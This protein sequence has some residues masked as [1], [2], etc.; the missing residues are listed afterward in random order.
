VKPRKP[1]PRSRKR[2]A[3][4]TRPR[5]K[6]GRRFTHATRDPAK[7]AWVRRYEACVACNALRNGG[8]VV[9]PPIGCDPHHEPPKS[10]GGGDDQVCAL[11]PTHHESRTSRLNRQAFEALYDFSFA[12]ETAACEARYQAW[13]AAQAGRGN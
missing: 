10:R 8:V 11:C 2:I 5:S 3:R 4:R 1:L 6:G 12:V 13:R 7:L 9:V